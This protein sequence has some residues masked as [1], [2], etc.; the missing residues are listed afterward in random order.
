[1]EGPMQKNY[2]IVLMHQFWIHKT[3][4][5]KWS[6][7]KSWFLKQKLP[8]YILDNEGYLLIFLSMISHKQVINDMMY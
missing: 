4:K 5:P 6:L 2:K 8:P 3:Y 7:P 1:M